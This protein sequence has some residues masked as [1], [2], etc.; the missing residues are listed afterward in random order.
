MKKLLKIITFFMVA[1]TLFSVPKS[2]FAEEI[3]YTD[4]VIPAMTSNTS[5]SGEASASSV[6]SGNVTYQPYQ[7]FNHKINSDGWVPAST[8][9]W[10]EYDFADAKCIT[11]YTIVSRK[12]DQA[13]NLLPKNWTFE[14]WDEQLSKWVVLDLQE[15][16]VDWSIGVKKEFCFNNTKLYNN[17]RIN[18]TASNHASVVAIGELEMMETI[19]SPI[20]LSAVAGNSNVQLSW[21]AVTGATGYNVKR[22][23]TSGGPYDTIASTVSGSAITFTDTGLTNGTTYYYVVSAIV[24]GKE[25]TNSNEA[26]AIP[27]D[28]PILTGN[29]ILDIYVD[30]GTLKEYNLTGDELSDFLTWYD[31]NGEGKAYYTFTVKGNVVPFKSVKNY[32]PYNKILYFDV[33]EY[34]E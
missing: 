23:L 34:D 19:S 24:S 2:V 1:F 4:N 16:I 32:I 31:A 13:A 3:Q 28:S 15:G 29:A 30:D 17:Y 10:L 27:T 7:T 18:I 11:K 20:N 21:S 25:S 8:T 26:S 5:P 12:P 6:W 33:K 14:A 9:A 22:S